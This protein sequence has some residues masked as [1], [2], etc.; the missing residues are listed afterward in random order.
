MHGRTVIQL[1]RLHGITT[2][3]ITPRLR[4]LETMG[5]SFVQ[6]LFA[7]LRKLALRELFNSASEKR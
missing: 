7:C 4:L 6:K 2:W 5:V 1:L 3:K